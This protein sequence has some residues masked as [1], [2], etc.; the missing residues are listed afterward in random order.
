MGCPAAAA[1][2]SMAPS[3]LPALSGE[4]V[5][6]FTLAL[7]LLVPLRL[8]LRIRANGKH[9]P[10]QDHYL[11]RGNCHTAEFRLDYYRSMILTRTAGH[12]A[13]AYDTYVASFSVETRSPRSFARRP[14]ALF[15]LDPLPGCSAVCTLG[16]F[17]AAQPH[18]ACRHQGDAAG[19]RRRS[20]SP[21]PMRRRWRR[22]SRRSCRAVVVVA[23]AAAH[24][25]ARCRR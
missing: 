16:I 15:P 14:A 23:A 25:D 11:V 21:R 12:G 5:L 22:G 8:F 24:A 13:D 6:W 1:R 9:R 2:R 17:R 7:A 19:P 18:E 20:R 4:S 10:Q 3:W